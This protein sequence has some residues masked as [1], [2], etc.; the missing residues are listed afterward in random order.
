MWPDSYQRLDF[1]AQP[2]GYRLWKRRARTFLIGRF[3]Q[4][5]AALEWAEKQLDP[6]PATRAP[7]SGVPRPG[8]RVQPAQRGPV[9]F[10]PAHHR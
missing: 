8:F 4:V 5:G 6:I 9:W 1:E 2:Q 10:H 7:V 3:P